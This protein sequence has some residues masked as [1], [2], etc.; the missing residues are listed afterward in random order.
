[1][2]TVGLRVRIWVRVSI[3][4]ANNVVYK[5]LEKAIKCGLKLTND[6]APRRSTPLRILSCPKDFG[7]IDK[8]GPFV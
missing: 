5:L 1:M 7:L 2:I 6:D 4:V 8:Q 3:R